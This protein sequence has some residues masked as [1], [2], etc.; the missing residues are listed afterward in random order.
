MVFTLI[1]YFSGGAGAIGEALFGLNSTSLLLLFGLLLVVISLALRG[2]KRAQHKNVPLSRLELGERNKQVLGMQGDL[3]ELM[4]EIERLT[5]HLAAQLDDKTQRMEHLM[6]E[7]DQRMIDLERLGMRGKRT[8][9]VTPADPG[10]SAQE[11]TTPKP[12]SPNAGRFSLAP[13]ANEPTPSD[14]TTQSIYR[15]ADQG[16]APEQIARKLNEHI[17]KVELILALRDAG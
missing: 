13:Q 2:Y 12:P 17:G 15:L 9:A 14:P 4:V 11:G 7:V 1:T 16:L 6:K 5:K 3:E 8:D 10:R